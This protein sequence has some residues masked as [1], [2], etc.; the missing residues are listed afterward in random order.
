MPMFQFGQTTIHIKEK[1]IIVILM[2]KQ[3][4]QLEVHQ[5]LLQKLQQQFLGFYAGLGQFC[6]HY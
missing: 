3:E 5:N 2:A 4:K 1:S 6:W